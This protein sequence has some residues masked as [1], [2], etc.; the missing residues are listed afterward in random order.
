MN[1]LKNIMMSKGNALIVIFLAII[2]HFLV[3]IVLRVIP[4]RNFII[5]SYN[6]N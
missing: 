5:L 1:V 2:V 6:K 4:I 3:L